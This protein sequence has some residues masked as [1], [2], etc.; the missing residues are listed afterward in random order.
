STVYP[1]VLSE[2]TENAKLQTMLLTIEFS[3]KLPRHLSERSIPVEISVSIAEEFGC[4]TMPIIHAMSVDPWCTPPGSPVNDVS[5]HSPGR[6]KLTFCRRALNHPKILSFLPMTSPFHSSHFH[7]NW[8]E[9]SQRIEKWLIEL[10]TELP[11]WS[12]GRDTFWLTFVTAFPS[13][14]RGTWPMWDPRIPLEG[15]FIEQWLQD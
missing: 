4:F 9:L 5:V 10:D 3:G 8:A 6:I 2:N 15:T 14:P 11:E 1:G 7:Q 12:W 13:F